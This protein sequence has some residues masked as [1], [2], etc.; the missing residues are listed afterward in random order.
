MAQQPP[1]GIGNRDKVL[2]AA[3]TMLGEEPGAM[4]SVR[5]V[6]ARAGVSVGSLQHHF[7][8]KR[9]LL[10]TAM[11]LVYDL[12]LPEDSIRD[13]SIPAK[14]RL[15]SCLQRMP[16]LDE[17]TADPRAAWRQTIE[18]YLAGEPTAD[19]EAEFLA[20]ERQLCRRIEYC[21]DVLQDEGAVPAGSNARRAKALLIV[22]YGISVARA[23]PFEESRAGTELDVLHAA[24]DS[25]L[26]PHQLDCTQ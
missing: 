15:M 18:R 17:A 10:D 23:L 9:A 2:W 25:I 24:V 8:T 14:D 4:M 5:A 21:L 11:T 12:V 16:N 26:S 6:A 20:I 3:V 19:A 7:P 13:S 1:E 22:T